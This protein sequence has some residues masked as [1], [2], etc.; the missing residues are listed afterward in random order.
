MGEEIFGPILPVLAYTTHEEAADLI[1]ARPKPLSA[2]IFTS[3][4]ESERFFL[5]NVSFGG[6]CVNDTVVHLSVPRLPF[7]GVG[8]SGMGSYHGRAGFDTFTHYKSVLHKSKLVDI[9]LRYPPYTEFALKLLKK[10]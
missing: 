6:G 4:K 7:G 9:P 8:A 5:R 3:D 1:N 10:L 2:Y